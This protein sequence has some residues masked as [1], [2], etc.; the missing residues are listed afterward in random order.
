MAKDHSSGNKGNAAAV[1]KRHSRRRHSSAQ[2]V[3]PPSSGDVGSKSPVSSKAKQALSSKYK[4]ISRLAE[5]AVDTIV[6]PKTPRSRRRRSIGAE[7]STDNT[8]PL[9]TSSGGSSNSDQQQKQQLQKHRPKRRSSLPG[10]TNTSSSRSH[11]R[12][13][14]DE[15]SHNHSSTPKKKNTSTVTGTLLKRAFTTDETSISTARSSLLKAPTPLGVRS[16]SP[17]RSVKRNASMPAGKKGMQQPMSRADRRPSAGGARVLGT[18]SHSGDRQSRRRASGST[19]A[20]GNVQENERKQRRRRPSKDMASRTSWDTPKSKPKLSS[21][22]MLMFG[23]KNKPQRTNGSISLDDSS[24][25]SLAALD[26]SIHTGNGKRQSA[27]SSTIHTMTTNETDTIASAPNKGSVQGLRKSLPPNAL[28]KAQSFSLLVDNAPS[29]HAPLSPRKSA[30]DDE[31]ENDDSSAIYDS[32]IGD[33]ND[34]Y[35]AGDIYSAASIDQGT[36]ATI[37]TAT[38]STMRDGSSLMVADLSRSDASR[39]SDG[40]G[41]R[42]SG[43]G[44]GS[45]G[46]G[47]RRRRNMADGSRRMDGS[48]MDRGGG[49]RRAKSIDGSSG[50]PKTPRNGRKSPGR[51]SAR[52]RRSSR[53]LASSD[54]RGSSGSLGRSRSRSGEPKAASRRRAS[55]S[56]SAQSSSRDRGYSRERSSS[57]LD[58]KRARA[59]IVAAVNASSGATAQNTTVPTPQRQGSSNSLRRGKSVEPPSPRRQRSASTLK[60]DKSKSPRARKKKSKK[61]KSTVLESNLLQ[62]DTMWVRESGDKTEMQAAAN[63]AIAGI[64]EGAINVQPQQWNRKSSNRSVGAASMGSSSR[65]SVGNGRRIR[66]QNS[67]EAASLASHGSNGSRKGKRPSKSLP[68]TT[69]TSRSSVDADMGEDMSVATPPIVASKSADETINGEAPRRKRDSFRRAQSWGANDAGLSSKS[70]Q[71]SQKSIASTPNQQSIAED[72]QGATRG[73]VEKPVAAKRDPF[74]LK[75]DEIDPFGSQHGEHFG[76]DLFS[77]NALPDPFHMQHPGQ[78]KKDP[79][80]P[81]FHLTDDFGDFGDASFADYDGSGSFQVVSVDDTTVQSRLQ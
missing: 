18:R 67:N 6:A 72:S 20:L 39:R 69:I 41:S 23:E 52:P 53:G 25:P 1:E 21:A 24:M 17:I 7:N 66:R 55:M 58:Q 76:N 65:K 29:H 71:A 78:T 42:E 37:T 27:D 61:K 64:P 45:G 62:L 4:L 38:S 12:N 8:T 11:S 40:S 31:N 54:R 70:R 34:T 57:S 26:L 35:D 75:A 36:V 77:A 79:L 68:R 28:P 10:N 22:A 13:R 5:G 9:A 33:D 46:G 44:S 73:T 16:K 60:S 63:E 47:L 14:V 50:V 3:P 74:S 43:S 56:A 19:A 2:G 48:R 32:D 80:G 59:A 30:D 81:S 15:A 49:R 51:T